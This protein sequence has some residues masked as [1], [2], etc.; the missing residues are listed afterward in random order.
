L[1][2]VAEQL[3]QRARATLGVLADDEELL[4]R[5]VETAAQRSELKRIPPAPDH[6][7]IREIYRCSAPPPSS[8]PETRPAPR[9]GDR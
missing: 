5:A 2:A 3:R 9:E 1:E 4:R 8:R 7:E 6:A